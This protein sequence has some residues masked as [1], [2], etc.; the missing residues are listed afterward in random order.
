MILDIGAAK[1]KAFDPFD[2]KSAESSTKV[3]LLAIRRPGDPPPTL[4][5]R[6]RAIMGKLCCDGA[7]RGLDRETPRARRATFR[8]SSWRRGPRPA[9]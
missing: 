9:S 5:D 4:T 7:P 2:P 6:Q 3:P 8:V 1:A